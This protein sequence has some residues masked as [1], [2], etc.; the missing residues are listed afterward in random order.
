MDILDRYLAYS[1]EILRLALLGIAG[2]AFLLKEIVYPA[3]ANKDFELRLA[4]NHWILIG[5]LV[6]L[7]LSA[8]FALQHRIFATDSVACI[9]DHLRYRVLKD[10]SGSDDQA[11]QVHLNLKWSAR[12]LQLSA[13][14]LGLG[15]A[16]VAIT[17]ARVLWP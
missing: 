9:I 13:A 6:S 11:S 3:N 12:F 14:F 10:Q 17:F 1:K 5:G 7:G 16:A 4:Q 2:Y 15:A 8:G